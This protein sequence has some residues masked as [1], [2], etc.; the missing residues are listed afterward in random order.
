MKEIVMD[1]GSRQK[2]IYI[3]DFDRT[4]LEALIKEARNR[5]S[6]DI[7][8]LDDLEGELARAVIVSSEDVPGDVVTMNSQVVLKDLDSGEVMTI[9][10]SFPQDAKPE[11]N[12]ISVL[13]PV[14]TAIIGYRTGDLVEW[15]VPA[16]VRRLRVEDIL[17]Q[18]E[19]AGDFHL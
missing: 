14:G 16:G 15:Q 4:R 19:S 9:A 17:Y 11:E 5:N 8:H 13:A 7:K 2:R 10:L 12:R 3:T 18:P 1:K 6:R